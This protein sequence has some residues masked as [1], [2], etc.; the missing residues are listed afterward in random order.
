MK[1]KSGIVRLFI[2]LFFALTMLDVSA[3]T[4]LPVI[5]S[6]NTCGGEGIFRLDF[7]P[8]EENSYT[9][10][11]FG[12]NSPVFIQYD[13]LTDVHHQYSQTGTYTVTATWYT[14]YSG[15]WFST[16]Y[17]T[18][19]EYLSSD[20]L[21]GIGDNC[22]ALTVAAN[23]ELE[24]EVEYVGGNYSGG[25]YNWSEIDYGD[26]TVD[27]YGILT[28]GQTFSHIYAA[29]G[30][31]TVTLTIT[32]G[33]HT[34]P[35]CSTSCS[36]TITVAEPECCSNFSPLPQGNYLISAWVKEN[37][38]TQVKNYDNAY[39]E[40]E[41]FGSGGASYQFYPSGDIVDGWQRI[42]GEFTIP[43]GT[44]DMDIHLSN[45]HPSMECYFDDIR[46]HP[47]NASMKSYVYDPE[48]LWL[49]A[50]LDDNNYATFY[51]Y[52]KEGQLVRIKKETNR[53]VMTIQE[54][55]SSNPKV[56]Q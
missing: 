8:L 24:I 42:I 38:P 15:Q 21:F 17:T 37:Q 44:T 13:Q 18:T 5:I 9:E 12:D 23:N 3:H 14:Y 52:D 54:T 46:V 20:P 35:F 1:N 33:Y 41:F 28:N 7:L 27:T 47:F 40:L 53:G 26:G 48:T 25:V 22:I 34:G 50:E 39:I 29:P 2:M 19:F 49:A 30:Q 56:E 16:N 4:P 31:Y 55:R 6:W 11:D 43:A 36:A 10:W 32:A 51:E 45:D